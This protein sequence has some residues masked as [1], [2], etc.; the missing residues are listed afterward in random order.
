MF[1]NLLDHSPHHL[2]IG[3]AD[4][5]RVGSIKYSGVIVHAAVKMNVDLDTVKTKTQ[6]LRCL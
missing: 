1:W 2:K 3:S 6:V 5:M 4:I